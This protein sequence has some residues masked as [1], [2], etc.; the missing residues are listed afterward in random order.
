MHFGKYTNF[1][2]FVVR[3]GRCNDAERLCHRKWRRFIQFDNAAVDVV[4]QGVINCSAAVAD[5]V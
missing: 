4:C 5:V 2:T 1:Y 3:G